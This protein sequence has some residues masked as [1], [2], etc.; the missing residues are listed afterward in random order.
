LQLGALLKKIEQDLADAK[1]SLKEKQVAYENCIK[2]VSSLEKS[3]TDHNRS[4]DTRLKDLEKKIKGLKSQMQSSSKE[5]KVG[6]LVDI[7]AQKM[8]SNCQTCHI[9]AC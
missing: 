5:L 9:S 1:S 8:I 7:L 6:Y 2:K 3:I 4:R